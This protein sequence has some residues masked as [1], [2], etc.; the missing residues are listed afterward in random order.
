M[1][2]ELVQGDYL[3]LTEIQQWMLHEVAKDID[4]ELRVGRLTTEQALEVLRRLVEKLGQ[5]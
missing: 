1:K 5:C 2:L 4:R 3:G